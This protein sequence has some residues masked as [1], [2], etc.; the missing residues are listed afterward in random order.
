VGESHDL[1]LPRAF[2]PQH[3]SVRV[4]LYWPDTGE[5]LPVL[6]GGAA[7]DDALLI[8]PDAP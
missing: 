1:R 2:D 6:I 8:R 4:G 7:V 3:D 5:R